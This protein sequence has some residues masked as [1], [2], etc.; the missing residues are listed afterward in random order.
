MDTV[1]AHRSRAIRD[2]IVDREVRR[3]EMIQRARREAS[4]TPPRPAPRAARGRS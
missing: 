1:I 4:G 3:L 2:L